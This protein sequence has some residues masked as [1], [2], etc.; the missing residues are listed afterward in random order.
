MLEMEGNTVVIAMSGGVDSSVAAALLVEQGYRVIG[1]MLRLWSEEGK[2]DQNRCCT[3]D[4][5]ALARRVAAKLGIPFYALDVRDRFKELV[6][7]HFLQGYASGVTPNPCLKCNRFIRWGVLYEHARSLGANWFATGHYARLRRLESGEVQLLRGLDAEKDQSY[8][9]SVLPQEQLQHTL[10]PI[11][12]FHKH[13]V[14]ELAQRLGLPVAHRPDS[15][16]LCF[17]AGGDYRDFLARHAPQ[18]RQPGLIVDRQGNVLGEHQGLAFYTIG[19]RKGLGISSPRP[20]YVLEKDVYQNRLVVGEEHELGRSNL[21]ANEVNWISGNPPE[22]PLPV[23]VKIRYKAREA[24]AV[25]IPLTSNRVRVQFEY[26]LRDITPGQQ[27]VFYQG[28]ICLGGGIIST[29]VESA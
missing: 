2:E 28:D 3:P 14:R 4:A 27:C 1:M 8:V 11:G 21:I 22:T 10:F 7:T 16:D 24:R 9:L 29:E 23:E 26:P 6:V 18:V 5:M 25:V 13:E 20:L 12:E 19:Q 15:Q 17:L